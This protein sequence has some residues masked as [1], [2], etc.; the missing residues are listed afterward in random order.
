MPR[1]AGTLFPASSVLFVV[2]NAMEMGMILNLI[3]EH[4]AAVQMETLCAHINYSFSYL[5]IAILHR[6]YHLE[7]YPT[8]EN[9]SLCPVYLITLHAKVLLE[10]SQRGHKHHKAVSYYST[11]R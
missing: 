8:A 2:G 1:S 11:A 10:C 4:K 7:L 9:R 5:N 6:L 3:T